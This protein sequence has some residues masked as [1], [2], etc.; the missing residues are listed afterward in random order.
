M[1]IGVF[2]PNWIGD[3]VMATPTL[4]ALRTHFGKT[5]HLVGV[6]RPYVA[7]VLAGTQWLDE[8]LFYNPRSS[9]PQHRSWSLIQQLRQRDLDFVV[10]L[11]N[12]LRTGVLAWASGARQR[13]GYVRYGR[14]MLLSHKLYHPRRGRRYLPTPAIDAYLQ[15]AYAVGCGYQS[16][17]LELATLPE[18]EAAA[19]GLWRELD[20]PSGDRVVVLN[21][22]GAYGAAKHW[23]AEYFSLLARRLAVSDNLHVLINCG[24]A[25]RELAAEIAVR[26]D[27]PHVKCL[28]GPKLPIGLSKACIRRCRLLVSTDSGPR[29]FGVAFGVPTVSLF[30]PT[31]VAWSR[32]HAASEICLAKTVPCGPCMKRTCPLGHHRCMR[33]LGVDEVYRAVQRQLARPQR[34]AA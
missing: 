27:H 2:L 33:E 15:L 31:D 22:G 17:Q 9:D 4:R 18:D 6:M 21:S 12:S 34:S 26:A 19:D 7:D 3:V 24:P 23:P 14:G 20:L 5:A 32:T 10:L 25:E 30:G 8:Q 16:P 1:N 29:F 11:T 13:V 28:S